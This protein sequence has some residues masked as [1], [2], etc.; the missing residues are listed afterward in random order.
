MQRFAGR[1]PGRV[2]LRRRVVALF[3]AIVLLAV[4]ARIVVRHPNRPS[5]DSQSSRDTADSIPPREATLAPA[6]RGAAASPPRDSPDTPTSAPVDGPREI[7]DFGVLVLDL[8]SGK[9]VPSM[10]FV[11]GWRVGRAQSAPKLMKTEREVGTTGP[12]GRLALSTSAGEILPRDETWIVAAESTADH[13]TSRTLYVARRVEIHGHV[14][15]ESASNRVFHPEAV[16]ITVIAL[17]SPADG[18]GAA[19]VTDPRSA[20]ARSA[21]SLYEHDLAEVDAGSP[22]SQT[23]EFQA[24]A[25]RL[26]WFG[27]LARAPGWTSELID[28]SD[29]VPDAGGRVE[30]E[31]PLRPTGAVYGR[32]V[33]AGGSPVAGA[34]VSLTCTTTANA[35]TH[36]NVPSRTLVTHVSSLSFGPDGRTTASKVGTAVTDR[37]GRYL[38]SLPFDTDNDKSTL[39]IEADDLPIV[40]IDLGR[41]TGDRSQDVVLRKDDGLRTVRLLERGKALGNGFVVVS[42][43]TAGDHQVMLGSLEVSEAGELSIMSFVLGHDYWIQRTV[44]GNPASIQIRWA[45]QSG[46]DFDKQEP[47]S[48]ASDKKSGR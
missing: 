8:L 39:V 9:P 38:V 27:V 36:S 5:P 12:D 17:G 20:A 48:P 18:V 1:V 14:R 35:S 43:V 7:E 21:Q 2:V 24:V 19:Q 33:D 47:N 13:Q 28:L 6:P 16:R 42:D 31:L 44:T 37:D 11:E 29:R 45:G 40:V 41:L 34:R 32:V 10:T 4:G 22:D 30:I 46:I 26:R 3:A 15:P 23:L 25:P